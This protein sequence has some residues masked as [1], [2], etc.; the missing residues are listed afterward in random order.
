M[1]LF[2]LAFI[3]IF[4]FNQMVL[5]QN[6]SP[7]GFNIYLLPKITSSQLSEIKLKNLQ[8]KGTPFIAE[9]EILYYQ[10]ETHEFQ[11][12]YLAAERLKNLRNKGCCHSFSV[13]IGNEAIYVGSFWNS[14]QSQSFD[15]VII[16]TYKSVGNPPYYTNTDFPI[17]TLEL[18][19]PSAEYFK[20]S[21]L[22]S[23]S[24]IFNALKT[25]GLLYNEL[26]LTVKCKKIA[27]TG[28][29]RV[30]AIFTFEVVAVNKGEFDKK[31]I[32]LEIFDGKLLPELDAEL[33]FGVGENTK[34]NENQEIIL[35]YSKQVGRT[36]PKLLFKSFRKK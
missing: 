17:L 11:I 22:R 32:T 1:K 23:D 9:K 7:K 5:A 10:K 36:E 4:L 26:E 24:R 33:K 14:N 6:N 8:P 29:R 15:G 31:E 34:F 16:N 25:A 12:D 20:Q 18:A 3:S 21:D 30:S 35:N 13:F 28:K 19:F 2:F 27:A